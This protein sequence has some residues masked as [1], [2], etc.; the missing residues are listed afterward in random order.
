MECLQAAGKSNYKS[1]SFPAIGTG[2]LGFSKDESALIMLNAVVDFAQK[3]QKKLEVFFI[4]YPYDHETFQ[5][6]C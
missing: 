5:V 6:F 3:F 2:A 1:I 4:I